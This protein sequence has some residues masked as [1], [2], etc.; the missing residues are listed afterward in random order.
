MRTLP[1]AASKRVASH[2]RQTNRPVSLVLSGP[3]GLLLI[4]AAASTLLT[5][6]LLAVLAVKSIS[7]PIRAADP[8]I[9]PDTH[10]GKI[11]I[12]SAQGDGCVQR[13]FDNATGRI[14][15]VNFPCGTSEFDEMGRPIVKGTVGRLNQ[16]GKSFLDR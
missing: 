16:I 13:R 5:V 4:I 11:V 7:S 3:H 9:S 10:S 14:T 2:I 6:F 1:S 15:D 12:H 8:P